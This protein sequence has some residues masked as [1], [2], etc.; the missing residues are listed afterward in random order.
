MSSTYSD[1]KFEII[2]VGGSSGQWGGITNTNI[3]TAIE[4]AIAGM[5]T[6][7]T[8]DFISNVAT[9]TATNTP[10]AQDF[11]AFCLNI[12][13]T[14]SAAGTVNVPA[15]E[16]PYLVLNNS[17][18]GFAIT[19]KVSGLTGI[20]IPNGKGCLVYNNGTDVGTAI[21][22]L[23]SLTLASALPVLSG[24]TGV[25]SS[26]GSG[27]N[28]LSTSPTLVTP[29][30]GTPTSGILG[31]CTVDGANLVGYQNIP[32]NSQTADYTLTL[33]DAGK[34]IFHPGTDAN[35]RTFTIP[36]NASVAF[37]IG[38]AVSFLNM[39]EIVTIAI[40]SDIM[41]LSGFGTT[42]SRSLAQYGTATAVKMTSTT[43][44]ISGNGLT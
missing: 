4:Q 38:T 30:L 18:G 20:S 5:A 23:T 25:T 2:E 6:I 42:G 1:L 39:A 17:V 3:G 19:V 8:S 16:K 33:T 14:L 35:N 24:G 44:M 37:P 28:V 34:I 29:I 12:T 40:T 11:R 22:H 43:W 36:A 41:Y 13:A 10:N 32:V 15:I 7:E 26:T 27:S 31:N 21:T 9:L